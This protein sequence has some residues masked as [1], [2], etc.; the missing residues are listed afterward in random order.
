MKLHMTLLE[1]LAHHASQTPEKVALKFISGGQLKV[2]TYA[3][4]AKETARFARY[5]TE[6]GDVEGREVLLILQ[7]CPEL[8]PAF[9]GAMQAGAIPA[10]L[11]FPTPKQN[12]ESYWSAHKTLLARIQ[13]GMVL[14]YEG[15][16]ERLETILPEGCAMA[17]LDGL[18]LPDPAPAAALPDPDCTALL[19]HSSGTTGLKKGVMLSYR[20]IAEQVASYGS[21][22]NLSESDVVISWLPLYHDMGLISSFLLPISAGLTIV[23]M[24]PFEW[25][26]TPLALLHEAARH[27]ATLCWMPNFAFSHMRQHYEMSGDEL[28]DLSYL[29]AV[30]SCSEPVRADTLSR[31]TACFAPAGLNPNAAKACYAMAETVF[32]VA[33]SPMDA[34][35]RVVHVRRQSIEARDNPVA[36]VSADS[37]DSMSFVSNGPVIDGLELRIACDDA[38]IPVTPDAPTSG[39]GEVQIRGRFLF[40]G[41]ARNP[42]A[43]EGAFTA[44]GWYRTGDLGFADRGDLFICGREKEL[45][46]IHGKNFYA[47][48]V[49]QI[50]N[51]V[52]G[53]KPG[54][55]VAFS[56]VDARSD[57]EEC[58]IMAESTLEGKAELRQLKREVKTAVYDGLALMVRTVELVGPGTLSKTTSGKTSRADNKAIW[59]ASQGIQK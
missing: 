44:D 20:Q 41:Y 31:F 52:E 5:F 1:A 37:P 11:P 23:S 42:E 43:T 34:S 25:V 36:L 24:D 26:T 18:S 53:I 13:P 4:L 51:T 15:I 47:G 54:R 59:M 9:L 38:A 21:A 22:L 14:G 2:Q 39:V 48:D 50:V 3:E 6:Q 32:A 29:R 49:E 58:I 27:R 45:L 35:P 55:C 19:Q 57:S 10:M 7:H 12:P 56:V 28:P 17:T 30:I 40:S 16:R 8:Y 33:Q 46:I